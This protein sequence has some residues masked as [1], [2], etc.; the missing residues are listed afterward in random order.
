M[1]LLFLCDESCQTEVTDIVEQRLS[2][3]ID[4]ERSEIKNFE[5]NIELFD[6]ENL[7]GIVFVLIATE[8]IRKEVPKIIDLASTKH[9]KLFTLIFREFEYQN[10]I[11][12]IDKT[13]IFKPK[14]RDFDKY[15]TNA[16]TNKLIPFDEI[17]SDDDAQEND[18]SN[19]LRDFAIF[20]N[21][22]RPNSI[23]IPEPKPKSKGCAISVSISLLLICIALF[24]YKVNDEAV[25]VNDSVV[26]KQQKSASVKGGIPTPVR[27]VDTVTVLNIDAI[28]IEQKRKLYNELIKFK[29]DESKI[30]SIFSNELFTDSKTFL[31]AKNAKMD[32]LSKKYEQKLHFLET[33]LP[34]YDDPYFQNITPERYKQEIIEEWF[35]IIIKV[36]GPKN[37]K[38]QRKGNY[39]FLEQKYDEGTDDSFNDS[40]DKF[41]KM[42]RRNYDVNYSKDEVKC[43]AVLLGKIDR[44]YCTKL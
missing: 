35:D 11:D 24:Y 16:N 36:Y 15:K 9:L 19:Y 29:N 7:D 6:F 13:Q 21:D 30:D 10:L 31:R 14:Y 3:H 40:W 38:E 4:L 18:I 22:K 5:D 41:Y 12:N 20:I 39:V 33:I 8:K 17:Y 44:K 27:V 34:A 2:G 28:T 43:I 1:K 25:I 23:Q 37:K 42:F 32:I 26:I